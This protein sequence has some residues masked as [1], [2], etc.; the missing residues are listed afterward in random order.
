MDKQCGPT[1]QH[2]ELYP[3]SWDKAWW[4]IVWEKEKIY[5]HTYDWVTVLYSRNWH[6]TVNQLYSYKN[7]FKKNYCVKI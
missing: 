5:I 6:S 2:R 4:E 1:L 7:L 3:V